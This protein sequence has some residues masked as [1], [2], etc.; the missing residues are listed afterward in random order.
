MLDD[1]ECKR[2]STAPAK[3]LSDLGRFKREKEFS[4]LEQF[5]ITANQ[6][7]HKSYE[8]YDLDSEDGQKVFKRYLTHI[9]N[10]CEV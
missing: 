6:M 7:I 1:I 10:L 3:P 4:V 9:E 2:V 5:V 8:K